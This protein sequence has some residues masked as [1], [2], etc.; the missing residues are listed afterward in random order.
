MVT[1]KKFNIY[2][3]FQKSH[4]PSYSMAERTTPIIYAWCKDTKHIFLS[5]KVTVIVK[6]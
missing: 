4:R 3:Y 1:E 2:A 5:Y 6:R